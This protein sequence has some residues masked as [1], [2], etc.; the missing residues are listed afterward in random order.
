MRYALDILEEERKEQHVLLDEFLLEHMDVFTK[1]E[2][3]RN[4]INSLDEA[5]E[6]CKKIE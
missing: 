4:R 6:H 3:F 1:Q 5:I 2:M